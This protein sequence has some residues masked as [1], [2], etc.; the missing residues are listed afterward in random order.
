VDRENNRMGVGRDLRSPQDEFNKRRS[1][2]LHETNNRQLQAM[3]NEMGQ[4]ALGADADLAR[5][6]AARPDGVIPPGWQPV[7]RTDIW[8]G[9]VNLLQMAEAELDR[10]GPNPAILARTGTT[11]SGRSKQVDQQAVMTEDAVVYKGIHNW[12]IRMYRAMWAR[13]KQFWTAPDYVR[14]T[15]DE[16]AP[17]FIG[18]NQPQMGS[19]IVPGPDGMPQIGQVV[20]GYDNKLEELDVD[21]ILDVVPDTA[22]LADEQFQ[23]LTELA[24]MYGPQEVPFDDLLEVSSIP[25][26]SKLIEKRK[27]RAE[28]QAQQGGQGQEMQMQAAQVEIMDK[29]ASAQLKQAQTEKTQAETQKIGVETQNE[30]IRPHVEAVRDGFAMGQKSAAGISGAS[31]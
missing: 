27:Q 25:N 29:S 4:M 16:G 12:E 11:A 21:I 18:I 13:C 7:P 24:K 31:G 20:L 23:A 6:E 17:K 14:V 28:E 9:Q 10:Q 2:L 3:P 5:A 22:A 15:D 26:K 8:Q 19:Q 1:K 30:A